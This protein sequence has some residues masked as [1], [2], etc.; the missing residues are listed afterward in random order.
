M[1][2]KVID[3]YKR[4]CYR[5]DGGPTA[6]TVTEWVSFTTPALTI[7]PA[8]SKVLRIT[9]VHFTTNDAFTITGDIRISPWGHASPAQVDIDSLLNLITISNEVHPFINGSSNYYLITLHFK[10]FIE[11]VFGET[12]T[13]EH[14]TGAAG[15]I[16]SPIEI[17]A[18]AYE[19][20]S[21]DA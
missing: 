6:D 2:D 12:F 3:Y 21:A 19:V 7:T 10:P 18:F 11:I 9:D 4:M 8:A 14:T 5:D 15:V 13:I 1:A 17:A 16:G 20:A